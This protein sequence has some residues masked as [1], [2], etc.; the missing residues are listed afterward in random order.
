VV[1]TLGFLKNS[2]K[3]G[4]IVAVGSLVFGDQIESMAEEYMQNEGTLQGV[5]G[6]TQETRFAKIND[7][8]LLHITPLYKNER[9]MLGGGFQYIKQNEIWHNRVGAIYNDIS[10]AALGY[11]QAKKELKARTSFLS[12]EDMDKIIKANSSNPFKKVGVFLYNRYIDPAKTE[13]ADKI[14]EKYAQTY[15]EMYLSN[16]VVDGLLEIDF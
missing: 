3:L 10:D 12:D 14:E 2:G 4:A 9:P 5:L 6:L 15:R 1:N 8:T 16:T 13:G 7:G 11:I